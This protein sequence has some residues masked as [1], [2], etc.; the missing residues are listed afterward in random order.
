MNG[1][2]LKEVRAESSYP[3]FRGFIG[4]V[5]W[6]LYIGASTLAF[7]VMLNSG[8]VGAMW[9]AVGIAIGVV[10]VA[11]AFKEASLML[12]DIAD[13]TM[14]IAARDSSR[15]AAEATVNN[16]FIGPGDM[17]AIARGRR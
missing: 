3:V 5:T 6:V 7:I 14:G 11:T 12:V 15:Y 1:E 9:M 8:D 4:L 10:L 17:A 13:A 2:F 16:E